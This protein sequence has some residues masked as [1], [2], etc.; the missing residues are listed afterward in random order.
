MIEAT[1]DV[2]CETSC[3]KCAATL[4]KETHRKANLL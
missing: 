2:Q 4:K 3:T 1:P